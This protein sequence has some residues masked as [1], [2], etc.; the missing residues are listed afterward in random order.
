MVIKPFAEEFKVRS[1]DTRAFRY[2]GLN[3]EQ[4]GDVIFVDQKNYVQELKEVEVDDS[5]RSALD[6]KLTDK[7]KK[8]LR[9][10]C[11]QLL[12]ATSQTRPDV[13]YESCSVSN[14]QKKPTV[15]SLVDANRA[16]RHLKSYDLKMRYPALGNVNEIEVLAYGDATHASL[17]SGESQ[18]ANIIFM[19]GGNGNVAPVTWRSRKLER[20]TKS[21]LASEVS[22]VAD[23][24]DSGHL[25]ASMI[26]ELFN[27]E[28]T[29]KIIVL[30]DSKSLQQHMESTRIIQDPR[31]RVDIARMKQML[32]LGEIEIRWV[33]SK[34]QLAD[35]LTKK[36]TSSAQ[37]IKVLVSGRI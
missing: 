5:R 9:S 14:S 30:T 36:G 28:K 1:M 24:A 4:D 34:S 22:A 11:G 7:E 25:V 20:V 16:V 23:S 19:S 2:L 12:W 3:V 21:P 17:P 26:R 29:P 10:I 13:S 15:Q 32:E 8:Q 35:S 27:L 33:C 18:G 31:L 6:D 37:L